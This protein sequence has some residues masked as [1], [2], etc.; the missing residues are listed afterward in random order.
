MRLMYYPGCTVKT[1]ARA[2]EKAAI[3]VLKEFNM[4]VIELSQ[5]VCCGVYPGLFKDSYYHLV[6]P[7]RNLLN[8]QEEIR[9][10]GIDNKYLLTLC[11]MCFNTLKTANKRYLEDNL[12]RDR[13]SYFL[14]SEPYY[15]G[16]IKVVHFMEVIRDLVGLKNLGRRVIRPLRGIRAAPFYGCYLLRPEGIGIDDPENPRIM[17]EI[18]ESIGT[19]AIDYPYRNRCCGGYLVAKDPDAVWDRIATIAKSAVENGANIFV[20]TCPLCAFNLEEGQKRREE[21]IGKILPV[22]FEPEL[23]AFA[24]GREEYL[25]EERLEIL[26]K[27]VKS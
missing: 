20:T 17:E 25:E 5:W 22:F 15:E 11:S 14:D 7:I 9:T 18:L 21:D 27:L 10:K 12:V 8:A 13:I 19:E 2:Y 6:S 3:G 23:I 26:K 16:E 24:M 4:E 1:T